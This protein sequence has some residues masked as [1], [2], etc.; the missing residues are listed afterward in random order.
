VDYWNGLALL[1]DLGL[2]LALW[3][4]ARRAHPHWLRAA[5][6]VFLY[7]LM[8]G[9]L[10]TA[11]RAGIAVGLVAVVVWLG[12]GGPR[13]E[14]VAALLLGGGTGLGVGV[15][16]LS[17]PGLADDS[18]AHS[19]RVHDGAWFALVF[20]LA[21]VAVAG[22]AYLGSLTEERR[23]L[24]ERERLLVGRVALG[25]LA[26]GAA[27]GVIVLVVAAKPQGWF[28]DFTRA[29]TNAA[30][31]STVQRLTSFN[32]NSRWQWWKEA[33]K[34]FEK[35]P[36]RGTG[37][38]SFELTDRM[39]RTN[40][41]VFVT[42]PHNVPLQFLSETGI[43]GFLLALGSVAAAAVGVVRRVRG[44]PAGLALAVGALAYVL[45][46]VV[47]FDWDFVAVTG[48]FLLSAGVLLG[49]GVVRRQR[50]WTLAPVP[51]VLALAVAYSLL[52]PWF[53]QRAA[54]SALAALE[55]GR[56]AQAVGHARDARS[57]NPFSLEPLFLE[58]GAAEQLGDL[59]AAR[60][61]YV[62]AIELQPLN[63]RP[64][65]ELGSFEV[66]LLH[67]GAAIPPL[68]RAVELDRHGTLAP[69]LLKVAKQKAG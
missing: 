14:G 43:V 17:R 59:A 60:S 28:H 56:P 50:Q 9:L 37:A 67:Y 11:S 42:E 24:L 16:A 46:S 22:L 34:A 58:A 6:T 54:D 12:F 19:V 64:W 49:G 62:K 69:A 35:Q 2:P 66:D 45:H 7:G 3:L 31:N 65:Y 1:F 52:S 40:G 29:P 8:I 47:D 30:A 53:A 4:A 39:F 13:I 57:L 41:V 36:L 55:A 61:L 15:W 25:A 23:P 51:V 32:S 44:S 38:G 63:W 48:P 26:V 33:W 21:A 27:A 5:G 68:E 18:Q 10:L 20:V